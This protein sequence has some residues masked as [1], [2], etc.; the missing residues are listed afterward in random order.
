MG[1]LV[2]SLSLFFPFEEGDRE[3]E[4]EATARSQGVIFNLQ[5]N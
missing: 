3:K 5:E 1:F 4:Q 2:P